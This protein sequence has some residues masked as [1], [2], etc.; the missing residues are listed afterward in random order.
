[1]KRKQVKNVIVFA[2]TLI[3][4]YYNKS[5]TTLRLKRDN[6]IYLRLH[7]KYEILNLNNRKL[8]H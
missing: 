2:N 3:K 4:V 7:Y 8:H 1:M 5:H 6:I